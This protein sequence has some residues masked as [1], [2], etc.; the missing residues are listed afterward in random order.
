[1]KAIRIH[2]HGGPV[3]LAIDDIA[4]PGAPGV[5]EVKVKVEAMALNHLNLWVLN[6]MPHIK[7]DLPFIMGSDAAG[8][9]V[10]V[11]Q[12]VDSVV[13]GDRVILCPI[14]FDPTSPEALAGEHSM[15]KGFRM[16]GE[17]VNGF[18]SEYT[19]VKEYAVRKIADTVSYPDAAA[20]GVIFLTAWRMLASRARILP[21]ETVLIHGIGGGVSIAALKIANLMGARVIVTSGQKWKI[22]AAERAGAVAG[23][24]YKTED[25]AAR[26]Y[27]L[28]GKQGVDVVV[29]S[30][31]GSTWPI[32]VKTVKPGGRIVTCG[33][34]AGNDP[35]AD[36]VRI[37]WKQITIMGSTM[38]NM[39]EF[40]QVVELL[41]QGKLAAPI[42]KVFKIE[43]VRFAYEHLKGEDQFGK[44]VLEWS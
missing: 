13:V 3:Q 21:G 30:V 31:G 25:V 41:N 27:E 6:G 42:D 24:N 5:G 19:L 43:E 26:C 28:T 9:V 44:V 10:E 39:R 11:G 1:M 2:E 38:G 29:D 36:L 7:Q 33:A 35:P 32:S 17:H 22:D 14:E 34:T 23:I 8:E 40:T 4:E 37:F 18:D 16:R 12:G 15:G 20:Y